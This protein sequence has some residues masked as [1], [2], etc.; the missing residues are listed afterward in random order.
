MRD[1]VE[2]QSA[3]AAAAGAG[4]RHGLG[5]QTGWQQASGQW[6]RGAAPP[7]RRRRRAGR[8]LRRL[9]DQENPRLA[10]GMALLAWGSVVVLTLGL[11]GV[12]AL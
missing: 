11:L 10:L 9:L 7:R 1:Y 2:R 8:L 5:R 3:M 6:S 12:F 4:T